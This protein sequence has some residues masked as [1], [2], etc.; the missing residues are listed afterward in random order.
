[1]AI[2]VQKGHPV[3]IFDSEKPFTRLHGEH[4]R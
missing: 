4:W 1:L 2:G 3:D